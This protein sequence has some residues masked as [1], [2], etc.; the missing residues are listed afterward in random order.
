MPEMEISPFK[1]YLCR[2][3]LNIKTVHETLGHATTS[4]TLDVYG[5][6]S[7]KMKKESVQRMDASIKGI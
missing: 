6:F 2:Y 3:C 4:L 7:D 5:H 1:A